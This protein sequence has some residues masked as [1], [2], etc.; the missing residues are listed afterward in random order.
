M[1]Y[2]R[3]FVKISRTVAVIWQFSD[4]GDGGRPP[5]E[6]QIPLRYPDREPA[7]TKIGIFGD[8]TPNG[9][10]PHDD[11]QKV[12]I[13]QKHG[14]KSGCCYAPFRGELCPH[15]TQCGL[16]ISDVV[17]IQTTTRNRV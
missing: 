5:S 13:A 7:R 4:F 11:S 17:P 16:G 14:A 10:Q 6:G 1:H 8:L 3:N 15:L 12:L 2:Q 9:Q